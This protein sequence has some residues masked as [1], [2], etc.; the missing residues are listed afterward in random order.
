MK[1]LA[2]LVV[3]VVGYGLMIHAY[4][5]R[6]QPDPAIPWSNGLIIVVR[7][8]AE[9]ESPVGHALNTRLRLLPASDR[10]EAILAALAPRSRAAAKKETE[11]SKS[12]ASLSASLQEQLRVK[13]IAFSP[14]QQGLNS[15]ILTSGRFPESAGEAVVG[16]HIPDQESIVVG[17]NP[18]KIVGRLR[19]EVAVF[20]D[21]VLVNPA[22]NDDLFPG[23][24]DSVHKATLIRVDGG[25]LDRKTLE[26]V[27][28]AFPSSRFGRIIPPGRLDRSAFSRYLGGMAIFLLGGSGFLIGLFR[29]LA[30]R[31]TWGWIAD[32][33]QELKHFG[34]LVWGVHLVYFAL[35]I[36]TATAIYALPEVQTVLLTL[37]TGE[38]ERKGGGPLSVAGTA[39]RSGIIPYAALVT[40]IVNF[41]IGALAC[42]TLPSMVIPG[43]GLLIAIVRSALW[44][45]LLAPSTQPM[46]FAMIP[47][48]IT[49]LLEG[50]G[51]ILS[52]VFAALIPV[53][54][55]RR[56]K[57]TLVQMYSQALMINLKGSLLVAIVLIVAALYEATEVILLS[58][59]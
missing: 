49:L 33:L 4:R 10:A 46:A 21:A 59:I 2:W 53:Y 28:E 50:E 11:A 6:I 26:Q 52:A 25:A 18:L 30:G 13:L 58:R 35:V 36:L 29:S 16:S 55:F 20:A 44:G 27:A 45:F 54:L 23:N 1:I 31:W 5:S 7:E 57:G 38:I 19:P 51:Y 32:A 47:H 42:I 41:F 24:D 8:G 3:T 15:Q 17:S 22:D 37:V 56:G 34:K 43:S 48:S 14:R 40:F 12:A 39:Y 9:G